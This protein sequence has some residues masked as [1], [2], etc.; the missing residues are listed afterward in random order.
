MM[1]AAPRDTLRV[2]GHLGEWMQGLLGPG[3]PVALISC[4]CPAFWVEP[5]PDGQ[6]LDTACAQRLAQALGIDLPHPL[7]RFRANSPLGGGAG[8][9]TAALVALVRWLGVPLDAVDLARACAMAEGASDPLMFSAS[10]RLLFASRRGEIVD[11]LPTLPPYRIVGG[12]WG[13]PQRTNPMDSDFPDI[14][15]LVAQWRVA[16]GLAEC[17]A[18]ASQSA[19]RCQDRRGPAGDPTATLAQETGALGWLRA[20]TGSARGL[21][22]APGSDTARAQAALAEAGY[23][24]VVAFD[25][26]SA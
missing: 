13:P 7:P 15:D 24:Q 3:G 16:R 18:L 26:G 19:Q 8:T 10:D 5:A 2:T 20:H 23:A 17:A 21:I 12:F 14:S 22:F 25:G 4:P 9:S 11:H 6:A 1:H